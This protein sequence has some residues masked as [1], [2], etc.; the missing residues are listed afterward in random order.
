MPVAVELISTPG[1]VSLVVS[2]LP[3]GAHLLH[4]PVDEADQRHHE[5]RHAR[6]GDADDLEWLELPHVLVGCAVL[7]D[8]DERPAD[9]LDG[10][11]QVHEAFLLS[12]AA[13]AGF[14]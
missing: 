7:A 11:Q 10:P 8:A 6:E 5:D 14:D 9:R 4:D 2:L 13:V 12:T 1:S 3:R